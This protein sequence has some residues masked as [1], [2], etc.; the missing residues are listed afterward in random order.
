MA[1]GDGKNNKDKKVLKERTI[2]TPITKTFSTALN[3]DEKKARGREAYTDRDNTVAD[4]N[5]PAY[6]TKNESNAIKEL[7]REDITSNSKIIR[8]A[9]VKYLKDMGKLK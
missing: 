5:I 4:V 6:F 1:F 8:R 9:I 2:D 3:S 7:A